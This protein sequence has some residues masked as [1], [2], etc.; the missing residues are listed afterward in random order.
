MAT[1]YETFGHYISVTGH[2][3]IFSN[4]T[5]TRSLLPYKVI[6]H[7]FQISSSYRQNIIFDAALHIIQGRG[8]K[9]GSFSTARQIKCEGT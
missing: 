1:V 3:R 7:L 5:F 9:S 8:F 6:N 4:I 2:W